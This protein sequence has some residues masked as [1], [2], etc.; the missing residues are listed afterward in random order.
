[1]TT[2]IQLR[3]V[4]SPHLDLLSAMYDRFDPLGAALGL[5][6]CTLEARHAWVGS[7]ICQI[8]NVAAFSPAGEVVGHSFL[9][10]DN[11]GSAEVAVFVHQQFRRRGIGA[12]L[13]RKALELGRAAHLQRAWAVTAPENRAALQLLMSCGFCLVQSDSD[14]IELGID[15]HAPPDNR[16]LVGISHAPTTH[17]TGSTIK[18]EEEF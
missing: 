9:A 7:A 11:P 12:T 3:P 1:M 17:Q 16:E 18:K 14:V 13:L 10:A 2:D 15:L 6:P 4:G 8:V 5:P